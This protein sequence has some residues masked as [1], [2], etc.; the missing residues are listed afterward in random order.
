MKLK[1]GDTITD[2]KEIEKELE[3]FHCNM[4][5]SQK[6][7]EPRGENGNFESF[8]EGYRGTRFTRT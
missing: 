3:D 6:N 5:I 2:A 4:S 7:S 8:V 1:D